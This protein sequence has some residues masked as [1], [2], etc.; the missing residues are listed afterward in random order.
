MS[1]QASSFIERRK[2]E[3]DHPLGKVRPELI[4]EIAEEL[5]LPVATGLPDATCRVQMVLRDLRPLLPESIISRLD[6]GRISAAEICEHNPAVYV[7]TFQDGSYG[8]VMTS[9]LPEYLYRVARPLSSA[10]IR[11]ESNPSR[12]LEL[13][14]LARILGEIVWWQCEGSFGPDYEI[15]KHQRIYA[16]ELAMRA[17]RFLV[18]HELA[19]VMCDVEDKLREERPETVGA[20]EEEL[21]CDYIAVQLSMHASSARD[22]DP[23]FHMLSYAAAEFALQSWSLLE[24]LG[25]HAPVAD[26]H[27]A[28]PDRLAAMRQALRDC[29]EDEAAFEQ[30]VLVADLI[31]RAFARAADLLPDIEA[32]F[33][34]EADAFADAIH[35]LLDE[36]SLEDVPDYSRFREEI[37]PILGRGY[38]VKLVEAVLSPVIDGFFLANRSGSPEFSDEEISRRFRR[39]K[40]LY[41]LQGSYS[42]PMDTLLECVFSRYR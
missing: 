14:E 28:L 26:S 22:D 2:Q 31:D 13:D 10:L 36:C 17:Q 37:R 35:A 33:S 41:S 8:I 20:V 40:L 21:V 34:V 23:N 7:Q 38:P 25:D 9:A 18:A 11:L 16:S 4:A 12:G 30:I 5:E 3:Q 32:R 39:M 6:D 1:T 27:P 29:C 15:S 24:R 19:H 42:K